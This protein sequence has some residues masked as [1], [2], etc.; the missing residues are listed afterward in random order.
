MCQKNLLYAFRNTNIHSQADQIDALIE[1]LNAE[2]GL[3]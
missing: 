2:V 3:L 1:E